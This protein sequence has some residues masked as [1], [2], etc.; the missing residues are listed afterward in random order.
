MVQNTFLEQFV[1][2]PKW[3]VIC[4]GRI[5]RLELHGRHGRLHIYAVYLDPSCAKSRD[6]QMRKLKDHY[7]DRVHNIVA[8]DSNFTTS[9]GDRVKRG[10]AECHENER[11][12]KNADAWKM[13]FNPAEL[14]EFAQDCFTCENSQ[15]WS[16]I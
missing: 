3:K 4:K 16:R 12:Q 1:E 8:G 7:D 6:A 9:S 13:Q 14:K 10:D 2:A 11:D 15:G 5:G